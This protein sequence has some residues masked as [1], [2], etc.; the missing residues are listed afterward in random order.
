MW[1]KDNTQLVI[2]QQMNRSLAIFG[3]RRSEICVA[4]PLFH[5]S[6]STTHCQIAKCSFALKGGVQE[7]RIDV[8]SWV[9]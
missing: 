7:P 2:L 6:L 1:P 4:I 5:V 8:R 9:A 3:D